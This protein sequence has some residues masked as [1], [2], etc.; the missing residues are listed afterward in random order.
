[1][2]DGN[3]LEDLVGRVLVLQVA[4]L[5]GLGMIRDLKL[6][7]NSVVSNFLGHFKFLIIF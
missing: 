2:V 6:L 5:V 7:D 3:D 1:M 4:H